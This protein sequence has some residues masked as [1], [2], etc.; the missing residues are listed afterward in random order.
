MQTVSFLLLLLA[1]SLPAQIPDAVQIVSKMTSDL[2]PL[3]SALISSEPLKDDV[4]T[5]AELQSLVTY[6]QHKVIQSYQKDLVEIQF[7]HNLA[8]RKPDNAP[9]SF[10]SFFSPDQ[11][12][13]LTSVLAGK[14]LSEEN[15]MPLVEGIVGM[16]ESAAESSAT[17]APLEKSVAFRTAAEKFWSALHALGV[18]NPDLEIVTDALFRGAKAA[19]SPPVHITYK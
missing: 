18:G 1:T 19:A 13:K 12:Y 8:L 9:V 14:D 15:L 2:L 7:R 17:S 16:A 5:P 11:A 6:S 4:Y 3:K 10:G